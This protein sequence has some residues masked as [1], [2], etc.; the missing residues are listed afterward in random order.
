[1]HLP[2]EF[3]G[4]KW[5]ERAPRHSQQKMQIKVS[6]T[7][8]PLFGGTKVFVNAETGSGRVCEEPPNSGG[9]QGGHWVLEGR[10]LSFTITSWIPLESVPVMDN[11]ALTSLGHVDTEMGTGQESSGALGLVITICYISSPQ[12]AERML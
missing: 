4:S 10:D 3:S 5:A 2:P 11:K 8:L 6:T 1:M 9:L 7:S 12:E